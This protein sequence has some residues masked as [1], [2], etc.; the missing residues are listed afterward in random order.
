MW[1][2]AKFT[3]QSAVPV[4][5]G[6]H[7]SAAGEKEWDCQTLIFLIC[8]SSIQPLSEGTLTCILLSLFYTVTP[9]HRNFC[10]KL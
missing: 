7:A 9:F 10:G 5:N 2:Q 3:N 4:G 6:P 8:F 1:A